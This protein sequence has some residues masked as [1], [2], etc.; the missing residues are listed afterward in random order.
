MPQRALAEYLIL[1]Q[2]DSYPDAGDIYCV[3][4]LSAGSEQVEPVE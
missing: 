1:V 2:Y 4:L 3:Q